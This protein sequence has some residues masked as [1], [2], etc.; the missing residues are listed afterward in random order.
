MN[1]AV[2]KAKLAR[3]MQRAKRLAC[4]YHRLTGRPLGVTAEVAE[5][6]AAEKLGL[7]LSTVRKPFFDARKGRVRFQIKGRSVSASNKYR[8]RVPSI[9]CDGKFEAVL[10]VLLDR[11][12]FQTI[13]IWQAQR[14]RVAK[15]LAKPGSKARNERHS[16]GITQFKS[17]AKKVWPPP[18]RALA[19]RCPGEAQAARS[20]MI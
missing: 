8:G 7:I 16:M 11:K 10:L 12:A 1:A 9:K 18:I 4:Q 2:N 17:I 20:Q 15:R 6:E 13:E 19:R 14:S 5:C 3:L